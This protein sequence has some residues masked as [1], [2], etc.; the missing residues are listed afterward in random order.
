M[1]FVVELVVCCWCNYPW[2]GCSLLLSVV[3][4]ML[5]FVANGIVCLLLFVVVV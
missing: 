3:S 4:L 2:F 5:F 1:L